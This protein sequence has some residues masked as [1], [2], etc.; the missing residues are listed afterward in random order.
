MD[1][2]DAP[3]RAFVVTLQ[4]AVVMIVGLPLIAVTQPFLPPFA[5][6]LVMLTG[7]VVLGL[8][9]WRTA[10]DLQGHVK[11]AAEAIVSA[12]GNQNRSTAPRE[13]ERTLERAYELL[14]GLGEPVPV[15][16]D[17]TSPFAGRQLSD[18]NLRGRTGA[19]VIAISRGAEVVLVPD[20]HQVLRAGDVL[21]LAGPR[22]AIDAARHLLANGEESSSESAPAPLEPGAL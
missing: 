22:P 10:A 1:P 3:R 12:I 11:A 7:L 13:A 5:G 14:P 19:T 9:F 4:I 15:R 8:L 17:V 21:A 6:V 20:G 18:T 16:I 2:A